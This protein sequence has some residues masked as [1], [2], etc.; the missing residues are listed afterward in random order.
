MPQTQVYLS[1][2]LRFVAPFERVADIFE[3]SP[4]YLHR[5]RLSQLV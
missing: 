3:G 5:Q 4:H 1:R 2:Q